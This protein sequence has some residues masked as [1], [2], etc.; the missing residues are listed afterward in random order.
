MGNFAGY[1]LFDDNDGIPYLR[2][3]ILCYQ[4]GALEDHRHCKSYIP[5]T[6]GP[7]WYCISCNESSLSVPYL[8]LSAVAWPSQTHNPHRS[9]SCPMPCVS[10]IISKRVFNSIHSRF[11]QVKARSEPFTTLVQTTLSC[12][13]RMP[14]LR[15][16]GSFIGLP[17][18]DGPW[19]V[20]IGGAICPP[21]EVSG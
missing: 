9:V 20:T 14:R 5:M 4:S 1:G 17:G 16:C 10:K 3:C 2:T 12:R 19:F 18:S 15:R 21:W 7:Q 11:I 6:C 8:A 13:G